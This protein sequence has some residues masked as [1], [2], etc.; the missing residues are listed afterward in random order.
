MDLK[1]LN[2]APSIQTINE[3]LFLV[4][5]NEKGQGGG[6]APFGAQ[7][8]RDVCVNV[9][10]LN[11]NFYFGLEE[12]LLKTVVDFLFMKKWHMMI[13]IAFPIPLELG[14]APCTQNF[15]FSK[16]Y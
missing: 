6:I 8:K 11:Y 14:I 16:E 4:F 5:K 9:I 3:T 1:N 13:S 15:L 10:V 2:I 7:R 12:E